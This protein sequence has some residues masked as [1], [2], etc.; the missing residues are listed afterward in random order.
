M[1]ALDFLAVVEVWAAQAERLDVATSQAPMAGDLASQAAAVVAVGRGWTWQRP[2]DGDRAIEWWLAVMS[3]DCRRFGRS[4]DQSD[5]WCGTDGVGRS[6]GAGTHGWSGSCPIGHLMT[7]RAGSYACTRWG[8]RTGGCGIRS[9]VG[10]SGNDDCRLA[11]DVTRFRWR[12]EG[13]SRAPT[14]ADAGTPAAVRGAG[15]LSA[16]GAG[17]LD[18]VPA[19]DDGRAPEC[20][21][22]AP[23]R[24]R[25]PESAHART[26]ASGLGRLRDR[27]SAR[28]P[29]AS[30]RR[31]AAGTVGRFV[32]AGTDESSP[33]AA[34]SPSSTNIDRPAVRRDVPRSPR[35]YGAT[36]R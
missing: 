25:G 7:A 18:D 24:A 4:L 21:R 35:R 9:V 28:R 33:C 11:A 32:R 8:G 1:H 10:T 16:P 6:T 17:I 13:V 12:P 19:A 26:V 34:R 31:S 14:I 3:G 30:L 23:H 20:Q 15:G 36:Q 5:S 22:V 27:H 2:P 29:D